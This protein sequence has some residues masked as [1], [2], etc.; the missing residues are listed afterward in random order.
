[1]KHII[2]LALFAYSVSSADDVY[3]KTGF[4]FRN[5]LVV[6]TVGTRINIRRDG[7]SIAIL[8]A[9]VVRIESRRVDL[10]A[11][12]SYE[13]Y[14]QELS[15]QHQAKTE[16]K[17]SGTTKLGGQMAQREGFVRKRIQT[18]GFNESYFSFFIGYNFYTPE[19]GTR[20]A[21]STDITA[22]GGLALAIRGLFNIPDIWSRLSVGLEYDLRTLVTEDSRVYYYVSSG[23][24]TSYMVNVHAGEFVA[25]L[26]L[27]ETD[28]FMVHVIGGAGILYDDETK[29]TRAGWSGSAVVAFPISDDGHWT[30]DLEASTLNPFG[31]MKVGTV[32]ITAGI[33]GRF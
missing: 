31:G 13:L 32:G 10:S 8:V 17:S 16:E 6:D 2:V 9:D 1:V 3:L 19:A 18:P 33:S 20:L 24:P 5:V 11:K 26:K 21:A 30:L 23:A 7:K 28:R 4:V 29:V 15:N 27:L 12:S 22:R 14:S 25:D